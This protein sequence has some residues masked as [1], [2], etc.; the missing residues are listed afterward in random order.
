MSL[1]KPL[2]HTSYLNLLN[3][4][5]KEFA[6]N[7]LKH[8]D[9][10]NISAIILALKNNICLSELIQ[11]VYVLKYQKNPYLL[12][13]EVKGEFILKLFCKFNY[14]TQ[15]IKLIY[16][17]DTAAPS[18]ILITELNNHPQSLLYFQ[19]SFLELY[20][21]YPK[22]KSVLDSF[23]TLKRTNFDII[24]GFTYADNISDNIKSNTPVADYKEKLKSASDALIKQNNNKQ[25]LTTLE[26]EILNGIQVKDLAGN[27]AQITGIRNYF[28]L[29][30]CSTLSIENANY[31]FDINENTL[32]NAGA[33]FVRIN[34]IPG[35]NAQEVIKDFKYLFTNATSSDRKEIIT[36]NNLYNFIRNIPREDKNIEYIDIITAPVPE[37][38]RQDN[39]ENNIIEEPQNI[40]KVCAEE[41]C[42]VKDN[43]TFYSLLRKY[44]LSENFLDLKDLMKYFA[45]A[46]NEAD[47]KNIDLEFLSLLLFKYEKNR[48]EKYI[49]P[50]KFLIHEA[51][52]LL[53]DLKQDNENSFIYLKDLFVNSYKY[54][55]SLKLRAFEDIFKEIINHI[56]KIDANIDKPQSAIT[57][58]EDI[59]LSILGVGGAVTSTDE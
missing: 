20:R 42:K 23:Q 30:L 35:F 15:P 7:Y 34:N 9:T 8:E 14:K 31:H 48:L 38:P 37:T 40:Y 16:S 27:M 51:C 47:P 21:I 44:L 11:S 1:L 22:L 59:E 18:K 32:D 17:Y 58:L 46:K 28:I 12:F 25:Y 26:K 29:K 50:S 6:L 53:S 52:K 2:F 56:D 19:T 10:D 39:R 3:P 4:I 5:N 57:Y 36:F 55:Q 41:L 24:P 49:E 43:N 33:F 13:R 45:A 54:M